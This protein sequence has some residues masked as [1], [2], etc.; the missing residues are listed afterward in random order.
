[1]Y[2]FPIFIPDRTVP[3]CPVPENV[4]ERIKFTTSAP[5][6]DEKT[7]SLLL[8]T[9]KTDTISPSPH[10]SVC[11]VMSDQSVHIPRPSVAEGEL[12]IEDEVA[13]LASKF[14]VPS[15][16]ITAVVRKVGT[17][18]TYARE[19]KEMFIITGALP[20]IRSG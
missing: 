6:L 20:V 9:T 14:L 10:Y 18:E 7:G 3:K 15:K 13:G 8:T 2:S 11:F 4:V 17:V 12:C 5:K 16:E 19:A 1:M